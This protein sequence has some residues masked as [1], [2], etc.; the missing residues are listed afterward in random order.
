MICCRV[1]QSFLGTGLWYGREQRTRA[2]PLTHSLMRDGQCNHLEQR[3]LKW[4]DLLILLGWTLRLNME[5]ITIIYRIF[6][7]FNIW[8]RSLL[9]ISNRNTHAILGEVVWS[10]IFFLILIMPSLEKS[11]LV[12]VSSVVFCSFFVDFSFIVMEPIVLWPLCLWGLWEWKS[13]GWQYI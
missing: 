5:R 11:P 3:E 2:H 6:W 8:N 12:Y 9:H 4:K 1:V 10:V 13:W 7:N